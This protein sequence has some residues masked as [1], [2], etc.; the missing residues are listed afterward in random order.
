MKKNIDHPFTQEIPQAWV[1]AAA[2]HRI[3]VP[4]KGRLTAKK[5]EALAEGVIAYIREKAPAMLGGNPNAAID[6]E[7]VLYCGRKAKDISIRWDS[8]YSRYSEDGAGGIIKSDNLRICGIPEL[9]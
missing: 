5:K 9:H 1:I 3:Y 2:R 8:Q 7:A 4:Y 6:P